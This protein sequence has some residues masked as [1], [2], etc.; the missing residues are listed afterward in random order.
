MITTN[1]GVGRQLAQYSPDTAHMLSDEL[2]NQAFEWMVRNYAADEWID[3]TGA[4]MLTDLEEWTDN[5]V[6]FHT[7]NPGITPDQL[8]DACYCF[9]MLS[10]MYA[11]MDAV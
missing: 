2:V 3:D 5:Q 9:G 11:E 7:A 4:A 8:T 10:E 1:R 6:D